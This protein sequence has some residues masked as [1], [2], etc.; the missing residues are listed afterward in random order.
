[1]LAIC[2]VNMSSSRLLEGVIHLRTGVRQIGIVVHCQIVRQGIHGGQTE[3]GRQ[4][5]ADA[6]RGNTVSGSAD[7]FQRD[8]DL[9][10]IIHPSGIVALLVEVDPLGLVL[11]LCRHIADQTTVVVTPATVDADDIIA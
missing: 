9:V 7:F 10:M 6:V 8:G 3:G 5:D 2:T 4:F 1:M 11:V